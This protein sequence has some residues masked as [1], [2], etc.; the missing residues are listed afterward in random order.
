MA[1]RRSSQLSYS[2][3]VDEYK[4]LPGLS[5]GP[6]GWESEH[7]P[8]PGLGRSVEGAAVVPMPCARVEV[9]HHNYGGDT[10]ITLGII[11]LIIGFIAKVAILWSIGI[12]LVVLGLILA[13]LG[14]MGRA[15]GGRRHYY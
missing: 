4:R 5:R 1:S 7:G 8:T 15:I 2:R 3:E 14:M 6:R 13:L 11:L 10:L 12:L 9:L